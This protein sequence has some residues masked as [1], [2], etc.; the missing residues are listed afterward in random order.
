MRK[1]WLYDLPAVLIIVIIAILF[2][3]EPVF[4]TLFHED[5]T[6]HVLVAEH[7]DRAGGIVT[8]D[9]W[10]S[11]P[12]GRP[13]NYPPLFHLFL[14]FF[15]KIGLEPY[16]ILLLGSL[17][18][19]TISLS[20]SW[21]GLRLLYNPRVALIGVIVLTSFLQYAIFLGVIAPASIVLAATP[22][23]YYLI[24]NKRLIG[25][26][27]L[28]GLMFYTHAIMPWLIVGAL[29][30]T[31]LIDSNIRR[32]IFIVISSALILYLPWG[33]HLAANLNFIKYVNTGIDLRSIP[34][35]NISIL[36]IFLVLLPSLLKNNGLIKQ[37]YFFGILLIMQV[38]IFFSAYPSRFSVSGGF[39][40]M[41][42]I[43]S[44]II[45]NLLS[46]SRPRTVY[47]SIS[48]LILMSLFTVEYG[49]YSDTLKRGFVI[50]RGSIARAVS[51]FNRRDE[52]LASR[53]LYTPEHLKLVS[54]IDQNSDANEVILGVADYFNLK[55]YPLERRAY[56]TQFFASLANRPMANPRLPESLSMTLI[57]LNQARIILAD[58]RQT[59]DF[60]GRQNFNQRQIA[61]VLDS[62]F[63]K[64]GQA[65]RLVVYKNTRDTVLTTTLPAFV[66]NQWLAILL[67][68]LAIGVVSYSTY[69]ANHQS[70]DRKTASSAVAST[71]LVRRRI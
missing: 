12:A 68:S 48:L 64:I 8:H 26:T 31:G 46:K 5:M 27:V 49:Q 40:C 54:L 6:Y 52:I 30:I 50:E 33:Y 18:G 66:F 1:N 56:F 59:S 43:L 37:S 47:F 62:N 42:I 10:E 35:I 57:D 58:Y 63:K 22:L 14:S 45:D 9:Y 21:L 32:T 16:T 13:H 38:P 39:L 23:L 20:L 19:I 69:A 55:P 41:A 3:L 53:S 61:L 60:T 44:V 11:M 36:A 2:W 15:I 28:L 4:L 34:T 7:F 71:G 29:I 24:L 70:V 67:A 17:L 25:A 65:D 51:I